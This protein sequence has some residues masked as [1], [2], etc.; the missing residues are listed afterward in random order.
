MSEGE[1]KDEGFPGKFPLQTS[2]SFHLRK[3]VVSGSCSPDR[4]F[5][6][7]P[8]R[9]RAAGACAQR[10]QCCGAED[11]ALLQSWVS[12]L[13]CGELEA[14]E[15]GAK[16]TVS[17]C[18]QLSPCSAQGSGTALKGWR[19]GAPRAQREELGVCRSFLGCALPVPQLM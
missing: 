12:A 14:G 6:P 11:G 18:S 17:W 5:V 3:H 4:V 15:N 10:W 8:Y 9:R 16:P 7:V 19:A 13:P 2:G 1:R